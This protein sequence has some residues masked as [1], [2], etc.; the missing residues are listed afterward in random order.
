[1][2]TSALIFASLLTVIVYFANA[3]DSQPKKERSLLDLSSAADVRSYFH[4]LANAES[5]AELLRRYQQLLKDLGIAPLLAKGNTIPIRNGGQ[6]IVDGDSL[7]VRDNDGETITLPPSGL[8][9]AA[10][11]DTGAWS[12]IQV[13][14]KTTSLLIRSKSGTLVVDLKDGVVSRIK[15]S[16]H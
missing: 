11:D 1:M 6:I 3:S 14:N 7:Q 15:T 4:D 10:L 16:E 8:A 13:S 9:L 2:K 5:D 12:Q